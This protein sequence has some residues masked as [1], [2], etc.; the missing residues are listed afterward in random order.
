LGT[1]RERKSRRDQRHPD[2]VP[3]VFVSRW[4]ILEIAKLLAEKR[5]RPTDM[6]TIMFGKNEEN[7]LKENGVFSLPHSSFRGLR[8]HGA[9]TESL[10]RLKAAGIIEMVDPNFYN[11]PARYT[12]TGR[13]KGEVNLNPRRRKR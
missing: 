3:V 5:L 12:F 2:D 8:H 10:K 9:T 1:D 6:L 4:Q 11:R 7:P 13:W